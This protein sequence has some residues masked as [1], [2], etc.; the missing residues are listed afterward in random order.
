M[1]R[2][3]TLSNFLTDVSNAVREKTGKTD[4]IKASELDTEI[5]NIPSG[6]SQETTETNIPI[7]ALSNY[8]ESGYPTKAVVQRFTNEERKEVSG[9]F[10]TPYATTL[11]S[12][13][14]NIELPKET[15]VIT[16]YLFRATN[17]TSVELPSTLEEIGYSSFMEC[18]YLALTELP[19][20][21]TSIGKNCF[22]G[23]GNLA[24]TELP[25]TL[26]T[27]EDYAFINCSNLA[28]TELPSSITVLQTGV[29]NNCKKIKQ[30]NILG[31]I[32]K[33]YTGC[34]SSSGLTTLKMPNI[35]AVPQLV[36][37]ENV[38]KNSPLAN[39]EGTIYVPDSLVED[40]KSETNWSAYADQIKPISEAE[41]E[42]N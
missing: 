14:E 9:L 6:S 17:I 10:S 1:A 33:F 11:F 36:D 40:F 7:V 25:S 15:K 42:A 2:T 37:G 16:N 23:C 18:K 34:F 28:L 35:E 27:L 26:V 20:S 29:F 19:S 41:T 31:K 4:K 21:V 8:N 32:E 30:L 12:Y 22:Q 3:D 13:L 5:K 38:F 24:L 39:G